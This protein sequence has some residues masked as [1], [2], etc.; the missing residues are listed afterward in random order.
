MEML[1]KLLD[2]FFV[3]NLRKLGYNGGGGGGTGDSKKIRGTVV[4][5]KKSV[6]DFK[7]VKAS[8][9]DR[10]HEFCGK[11]VSIQ[12]ISS[13]N[14]SDS[15]L[16]REELTLQEFECRNCFVFSYVLWNF[17]SLSFSSF[18]GVFGTVDYDGE[19]VDDGGRDCIYSVLQV[20][21]DDGSTGGVHHKKP[22]CEPVLLED[23]HFT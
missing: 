3:G 18:G 10:V 1:Q 12:L 6:L 19:A 22:P 8:V 11:G 5:M 15:G 20:G 7:D 4:L 2:M 9:L 13:E 14:P 16:S 23:S 17:F 21:G